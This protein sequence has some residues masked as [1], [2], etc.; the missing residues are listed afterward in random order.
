MLFLSFYMICYA[1]I[2]AS[3]L[4]YHI[5]HNVEPDMIREGGSSPVIL[6]FQEA[7]GENVML[8][9]MG[10]VDD[11]AHSQNEKMNRSNF[12]N[13]VSTHAVMFNEN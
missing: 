6:S 2:F 4:Y 12:L 8:L 7:I 5:V 3:F 13:G 1:F 10:C 9:P 11:G